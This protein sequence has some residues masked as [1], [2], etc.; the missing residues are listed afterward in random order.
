[1]VGQ[2]QNRFEPRR[3]PW[4]VPLLNYAEQACPVQAIPVEIQSLRSGRRGKT[5]L[6]AVTILNRASV[7]VPWIVV[8]KKRTPPT[9]MGPDQPQC[10]FAIHRAGARGEPRVAQ[11]HSNGQSLVPPIRW[12]SHLLT[13]SSL[14]GGRA[15][16]RGGLSEGRF[17]L[18][19]TVL[20]IHL[21]PEIAFTDIVHVSGERQCFANNC[22]QSGTA[23]V[24]AGLLRHV[25]E[26]SCQVERP[27]ASAT[28]IVCFRT[29]L[30]RPPGRRCTPT[31]KDRA[32][33]RI[34]IRVQ[35]Y[36]FTS[37]PE[38]AK[39]GTQELRQQLHLEQHL[40][41][42]SRIVEVLFDQRGNRAPLFRHQRAMQSNRDA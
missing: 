10:Q 17:V 13:G 42:C 25:I 6:D 8:R 1:M 23:C 4:P 19:T 30:L 14:R 40:A 9:V 33:R 22:A 27:R 5:D 32:L 12:Q 36:V 3:F 11:G 26:M 28:V 41:Q 2:A 34:V 35:M 39:F 20:Q 29:R 37:R 38:I 18:Q 16:S 15:P 7:I 31:D 24:F 21:E